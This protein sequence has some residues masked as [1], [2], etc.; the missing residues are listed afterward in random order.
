MTEM[1]ILDVFYDE[2]K[3]RSENRESLFLDIDDTFVAKITQKLG[4][5][6]GLIQLQLL[7]D[8]CIANGWLERTTAD[9][10]YRFLSLTD[11]G[12]QVAITRQYPTA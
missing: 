4:D 1:D 5:A 10:E 2:L 12:L 6:P 8:I 7:A 3:A 9:V 11:A